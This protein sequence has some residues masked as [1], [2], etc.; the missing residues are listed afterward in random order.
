MSLRREK[1]ARHPNLRKALGSFECTKDR[2][3][4]L[5]FPVAQR[6]DANDCESCIKIIQLVFFF[7]CRMKDL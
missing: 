2:A 3:N 6:Y 7:W 1:R 4:L 5:F